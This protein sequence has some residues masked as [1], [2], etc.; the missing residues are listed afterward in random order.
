MRL[1]AFI[2]GLAALC[3]AKSYHVDGIVIALDPVARTMLVSHR[4]IGNYMP[5]MTMP[6]RVAN[7]AE[8]AALHPGV[9]IEFDLYIGKEHSEARSIRRVAGE[10]LQI[11][12]PK[13]R[14]AIGVAV[15]GLEEFRGKVLAVDFIYTRCPLPDVC[16]RL[17]A[18]FAEMQRKFGGGDLLLLSI[19]VDPDYDTPAVL[20]EYAKRWNA[21]RARWRFLSGDNRVLA[22]SLGEVYWSGEGSIG[23]N[24]VTA[25]IDREG[26][27]A[28]VLE[29]AAYRIDQLESLIVHEL[30]RMQ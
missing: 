13:E 11:A 25:I 16:P 19:T 9:R 20:A 29:G 10:D 2:A 3:Q 8:L 6:F 14:L 24:A 15:P 7:G 22:A 27:L 12:P 17:S 4:P 18:N 30:R 26:R 5:A 21:D 1:C 28:A 23:H